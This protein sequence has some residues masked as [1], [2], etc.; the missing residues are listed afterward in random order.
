MYCTVCVCVC[1]CVCVHYAEES[2]KRQCFVMIIISLLPLEAYVSKMV[3]VNDS[4]REVVVVVDHTYKRARF[5]IPLTLWVYSETG[6]SERKKFKSV[7]SFLVKFFFKLL[8]NQ[9][10]CFE[11]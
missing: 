5:L 2:L 4:D 8:V 9:A 3:K 11:T 7:F 1:V 10:P 6:V